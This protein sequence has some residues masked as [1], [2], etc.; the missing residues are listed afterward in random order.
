MQPSAGG[1]AVDRGLAAATGMDAGSVSSQSGART[2]AS[3]RQSAASNADGSYSAADRGLANALGQSSGAGYYNG[4]G[5]SHT[6]DDE[7]EEIKKKARASA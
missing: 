3:G 1:N 5:Y 2:G 7:E 6:D 4:K